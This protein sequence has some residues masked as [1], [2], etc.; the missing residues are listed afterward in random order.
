[1]FHTF[2]INYNCQWL[3]TWQPLGTPMHHHSNCNTRRQGPLKWGISSWSRAGL[4]HPWIPCN[5][6][7]KDP[8]YSSSMGPQRTPLDV[9][10]SPGRA[11]EA[12]SKRTPPGPYPPCTSQLNGPTQGNTQWAPFTKGKVWY[13]WGKH[14]P[15]DSHTSHDYQCLWCHIVQH[16][17]HSIVHITM[18]T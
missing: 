8:L 17:E 7:H 15:K 11:F 1:M 14:T 12:W 9:M 18:W 5:S 2:I 13:T 10:A 4:L 3:A 6:L 16:I